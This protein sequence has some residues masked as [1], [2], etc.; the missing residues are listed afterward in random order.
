M[1][2]SLEVANS[3]SINL[4]G[5]QSNKIYYI[6]AFATNSIGTGYG[7]LVA[8]TTITDTSKVR[9]I[10]NGQEVVYGVIISPVTGKKWLDRNLGAN[11]VATSFDDYL[12][13]GDQFQ[14]GRPADG[15]Q[16]MSWASSTMGD[17]VN[18]MTPTL[19]TSDTPDHNKF[20]MADASFGHGDWRTNNNS[21]RWAANPKGP[22]PAGWHVPTKTEW[23][24]EVSNTQHGGTALTGGITNFSDAYSILKLTA[25]GFRY[26]YTTT[27]P[28]LPA[29]ALWKPGEK[30]AYW[31]SSVE[32][33]PLNGGVYLSDGLL[34]SNGL[35]DIGGAD[36]SYSRS[37]RCIQN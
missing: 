1:I 14:W 25:A 36:M 27:D 10:N 35:T 5:L 9:F 11:R 37:V 21:N 26:G 20:I 34:I 6:R 18:G 3:F 29:G 2:T 16:L 15:H 28:Y 32:A 8:L 7:K 31:S 13:Y 33:P 4:T 19:S 23:C 17:P 22:C 30:G 12:G 24:A